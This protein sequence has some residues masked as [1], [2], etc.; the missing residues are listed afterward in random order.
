[1]IYTSI[2]NEHIKEIK[3]LNNKKYR[4]LNGKFIIEGKH[5]VEEAIKN[6]LVEEI[7]LLEGN[8][9]KYDVKT[10]Y[11]NGK[12][13]KYITELDNPSKIIGI[14]HKK[15]DKIQGNH[16]LILDDIQDPGNLGTIIR[17]AVAFNIDTI[18]LSK[19]GVDLYN[20]KVL[21]STQGMIFNINIVVSDIKE[22][23]LKLKNDNYK[24][25]T[26][27]VEGGKLVKS[28]EKNQKFAIIIG[29]EGKG[30]SKEIKELSDE[31]IYIEMNK[32]C[33]SLNAAVATSII[34]YELSR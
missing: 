22:E 30:V 34:L 27:N 18:I 4:D 14:C 28:I 5:L 19:T 33:E 23:I 31:Y 10:N 25:L 12:V 29:N 13:M 24:I 15:N 7:L 11:V 1:M 6:N 20:S 32:K 2:E 9:E 21:R 17:S 8:N 16:I 26:T 3:K